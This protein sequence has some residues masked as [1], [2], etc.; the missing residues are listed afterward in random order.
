MQQMLM[1]PNQA[2]NCFVRRS[3]TCIVFSTNS[4]NALHSTPCHILLTFR[5]EY[6]LTQ[7]HMAKLCDAIKNGKTCRIQRATFHISEG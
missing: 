1:K 3:R 5:W 7:T 2:G 6:V 4:L